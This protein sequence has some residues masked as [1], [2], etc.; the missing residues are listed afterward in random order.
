MRIII[1][2]VM[3][4]M[5]LQAI[6]ALTLKDEVP[7]GFKEMAKPQRA[8]VTLSYGGKILGNFYAN[9][10][11]GKIV[12][13]EPSK[14]ANAIPALSDKVAMALYLSHPVSTSGSSDPQVASII[15]NEK[16][17]SA[18]LFI[19]KDYL[20]VTDDGKEKY[21]PLPNR[22]FSSIYGFSGAV[23]GADA[24]TPNFTFANDSTL[25]YGEKKLNFQTSVTNEGL[26]FDT[27]AASIEREGWEATAGLFR[28]RSMQ[29]AGDADILGA[30]YKTSP[31]TIIDGK[32]TSGNDI[33]LYL[34]RR[35]FVSIYREGRLYNSRI[36]DA[37]NQ[38][39]DT[40]ELP[41]GAYNIELKIQEQGG[42]ARTEIRF[43][44]KSTD[45]PPSDRPDYYV[46]AGLARAPQESDSTMPEVTSKPLIRAGGI[47]RIGEN[48][49]LG[50]GL[51][52]IDDRV[53]AETNIVMVGE[54][55]RL[56]ASALAGSASDFGVQLSYLHYRD[57]ISGGIDFRK[58]WVKEKPDNIYGSLLSG[59][60]QVSGS[61]AYSLDADISIGA[62]G[63]FSKADSS[64][65]TASFGP[66]AQMRLWQEGESSLM[67]N[68]NYA[69]TL[70]GNEGSIIFSFTH[71]MGDYGVSST[72]GQGFG[73]ANSGPFGSVR[74]W[75]NNSD[76]VNM[77]EVGSTISADRDSTSIG[78]DAEMRNS[79]M[80]MRGNVQQSFGEV[81]TFSYGGNF[82]VGA[83]QVEDNILLG[84]NSPDKAAV[85]I[86]TEGDAETDMEILI[87][88]TPRGMVE[89]G[90]RQVIY[91]SPFQEYRIML[92]PEKPGFYDYESAG[93]KTILYPGNVQR[94]KWQVNKFF[95]VTAKITDAE[96][97]PLANALLK[98]S[99]AKVM[100]DP[101]GRIQAEISKP[102]MLEFEIEG[103]SCKADAKGPAKELNGVIIFK[104]PLKCL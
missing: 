13:E 8:V 85:V 52:A 36:Y 21:L 62:R 32:K 87:N 30:S 80:N 24:N 67:A 5:P 65:A 102:E 92:K 12:F 41:E 11:P 45:I 100:T 25:S 71:R 17:L 58:T 74:G 59:G 61:M 48:M 86:E 82:E 33:I 16:D 46:Q 99:R 40:A 103:K 42:A 76:P 73:R 70:E 57:N 97:K 68:V 90:K 63:T 53:L 54:G 9:I 47:M 72:A 81:S 26:R 98:G 43:F 93:R 89:V 101:N 22:E 1:Y 83:A 35:S 37:G 10:V 50:A 95:V 29:L 14:I 78:A 64:G 2:I 84:G 44:A 77:L 6:A 51:T 88:N 28:S 31:R 66:Y 23:S 69:H 60:T 56:G 34:P 38:L 18:E 55:T 104:S 19:N 39:I 15:Y 4:M 20:N 94:M 49:G 7:D 75:H 96:G 79:Y 91:L 27:A 3:L